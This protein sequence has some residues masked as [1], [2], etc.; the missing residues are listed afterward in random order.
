MAGALAS[1]TPAGL[2]VKRV[3][4]GYPGYVVVHQPSGQEA[5]PWLRLRRHAEAFAAELAETGA[6]WTLAPD[7]LR[8][9]PEFRTGGPVGVV[10]TKWRNRAYH[11]CEGNE[12]YDPDTYAM[13]GRCMGPMS[14]GLPRR[15]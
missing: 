14:N 15:S 6:D 11:C 7:A 8:A 1:T 10:V 9:T 5:G 2:V 13:A 3:P 12:H 4:H